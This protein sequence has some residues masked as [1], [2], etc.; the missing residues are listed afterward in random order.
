LYATQQL[1]P[2]SSGNHH[3]NRINAIVIGIVH[4]DN[5]VRKALLMHSESAGCVDADRCRAP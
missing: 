1:A 2:G 4:D 5:D 3:A